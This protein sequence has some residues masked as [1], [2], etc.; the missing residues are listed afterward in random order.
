MI[1]HYKDIYCV[2]CGKH[3]KDRYYLAKLCLAC[4]GRNKQRR[5]EKAK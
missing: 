1:T 3:E 2:N 5:K 4:S